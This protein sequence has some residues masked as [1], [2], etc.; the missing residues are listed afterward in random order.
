TLFRSGRSNQLA[1]EF[2]DTGCGEYC[3]DEGKTDDYGP[4]GRHA[5]WT[6]CIGDDFRFDNEEPRAFV[7]N[8]D[9]TA[10]LTGTV[11]DRNDSRNKWMI[12]VHFSG[13]VDP[14]DE[15]YPPEGSPKLELH[16]NAYVDNGGPVDPETWHYYTQT[17]GM[18]IGLRDNEGCDIAVSRMGPAFQVGLGA[19]GKNVHFGASGWLDMVVDCPRQHP[20]SCKGDFNIDLDDDCR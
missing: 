1:F 3:P 7:E 14:G 19:N 4:G 10:R 8:G 5:W 6:N 9:G 20:F 17:E 18:I 11:Y 12:D 15:N 2:A 16:D 13:R